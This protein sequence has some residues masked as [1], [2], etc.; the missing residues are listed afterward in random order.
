MVNPYLPPPQTDTQN[1]NLPLI[2][3]RENGHF[4]KLFGATCLAVACFG[5]AMLMFLVHAFLLTEENQMGMHLTTT[6]P[7][8][9]GFFSLTYVYQL[10]RAP[11]LVRTTDE[12]CEIVRSTTKRLSWTEIERIQSDLSAGFGVNVI[13]LKNSDDKTIETITG[14][15]D[16]ERLLEKL[17]QKT[18]HDKNEQDDTGKPTAVHIKR[19]RKRAFGFQPGTLLFG[20]ATGFMFYDG[21][22]QMQRSQ[23]MRDASVEGTGLVT[24]K[25]LAPNGRTKRLYVQVTGDENQTK[26]HN[27]EVTDE[28]YDSVEEGQ[29]VGVVFVPADPR[30]AE[31]VE[32]EIRE[33]RSAATSFGT[34]AIG[35]VFSI[36]FLSIAV[37]SWLGYDLKFE[38]DKKGLVPIGE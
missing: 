5:G 30:M 8:I 10:S 29:E 22:F 15:Q 33:D 26:E 18:A 37:I 28:F 1:E 13:Q 27:L 35:F 11:V 25:K 16:T 3:R 24:Q 34:A 7:A 21:I 32:G 2:F 17:K 6:F 4:V 20:L 9:I 23:A 38:K 14:L 31:L 12:Y 36:L 19:G